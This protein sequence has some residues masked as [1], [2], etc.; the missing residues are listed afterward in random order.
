MIFGLLGFRLHEERA[1]VDVLGG[2]FEGTLRP[3]L[4]EGPRG[5]GADAVSL[6]LG[7]HVGQRLHRAGVADAAERASGL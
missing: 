3:D 5:R 6:L 4:D 1:V 7:E 2:L